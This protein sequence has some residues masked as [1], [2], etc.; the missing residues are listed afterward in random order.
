[1]IID[2]PLIK[3]LTFNEGVRLKAYRDS[4]GK[5][6]IGVGRNLT[7]VGITQAEAEAMLATDIAKSEAELTKTFAWFA[8]APESV[9]RGLTNMHFNMG[10]G[11][12]LG[13]REML[14]ALE[15][16]QYAEAAA[17]ALDSAWARQV[18]ARATRIAGLFS[19]AG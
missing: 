4:V 19:G 10:L 9:R 16:R 13:F 2:T 14:K 12:L 17:D 18:G 15:A 8:L 6:T 1:M 5:L 11:R 7:D 3:L